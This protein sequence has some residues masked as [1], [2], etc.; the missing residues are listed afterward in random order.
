MSSF[1]SASG[2][3]GLSG[4]EL[5]DGTATTP[6]DPPTGM[7]ASPS[8]SD[9]L[10]GAPVSLKVMRKSPTADSLATSASEDASGSWMSVK[11]GE[12]LFRSAADC[13]GIHAT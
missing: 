8:I 13:T 6:G 10:R 11:T 4:E 1:L 3:S 9:L 5:D 12:Q 7:S 2:A